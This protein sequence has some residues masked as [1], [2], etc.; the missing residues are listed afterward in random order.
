MQKGLLLAKSAEQ[1]ALLKLET[2]WKVRK[3]LDVEI[4]D[5]AALN[6]I[7]ALPSAS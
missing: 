1:L 2:Q 5:R 4:M 6:Q 3:G 7:V